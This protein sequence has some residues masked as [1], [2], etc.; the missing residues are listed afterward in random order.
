M[1]LER[2]GVLDKYSRVSDV[3][4]AVRDAMHNPENQIRLERATK[5]G[6]GVPA[7]LVVCIRALTRVLALEVVSREL[8]DLW[9]DCIIQSVRAEVHNDGGWGIVLRIEV[10]LLSIRAANPEISDSGIG[11]RSYRARGKDIPVIGVDEMAAVTQSLFLRALGSRDNDK[12]VD[13]SWAGSYAQ[14]SLMF[15]RSEPLSLATLQDFCETAAASTQKAAVGSVKVHCTKDE[16]VHL[17]WRTNAYQERVIS[18]SGEAI[19]TEFS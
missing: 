4:D 14:H 19:R 6:G 18:R 2:V 3:S 11:P 1:N 10:E 7:Q 8:R 13:T 17:S 5:N 9:R 15:K 12:N 16:N